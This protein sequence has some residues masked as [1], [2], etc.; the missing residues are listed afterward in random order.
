METPNSD[1]IRQLHRPRIVLKATAEEIEDGRNGLCR[2]CG[3]PTTSPVEPDARNYT[4]GSCGE[5]EVFGL[6][7]LLI[8]GEL[9]LRDDEDDEESEDAQ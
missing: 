1:D 7:E 6:E 8:M 2:A 4:C 5:K 9:E 3:E